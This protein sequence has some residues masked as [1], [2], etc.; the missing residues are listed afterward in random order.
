MKG[1]GLNLGNSAV[2]FYIGNK[3]YNLVMC[4]RDGVISNNDIEM[5]LLAFMKNKMQNY[6]KD[7]LSGEISEALGRGN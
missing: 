3:A 6:Q 1:A 7:Q 5:V 4:D 2:I